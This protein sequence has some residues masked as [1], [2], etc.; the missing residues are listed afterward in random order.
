MQDTVVDQEVQLNRILRLMEEEEMSLYKR[1]NLYESK[2]RRRNTRVPFYDP[3][4]SAIDYSSLA[5][6]RNKL[7]EVILRVFLNCILGR[8]NKLERIA[9]RPIWKID[10]KI[11]ITEIEIDL[12]HFRFELL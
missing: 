5:L 4:K 1:C 7:F 9:Q 11:S 12:N 2:S 3:F 8:V 6:Q 10:K